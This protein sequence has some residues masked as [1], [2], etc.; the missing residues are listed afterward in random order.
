MKKKRFLIVKVILIVIIS[1]IIGFGIYTWNNEMMMGSKLP[2]PL[3]FGVAEVLSDSM[4]PT[5]ETGDVVVIV[6]QDKYEIGDIVAFQDGSMVVTH[7]II[8]VNE[9]GDFVTK[10]DLEGNSVDTMPLK[11]IYIYGKVVMKFDNMGPLVRV[12]K[13]PVVSVMILNGSLLLK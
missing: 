2:M 5:F 1:V 3:G 9:N 13:S 12:I 4:Y 6:P 11:E 7:R 10:G 8:D